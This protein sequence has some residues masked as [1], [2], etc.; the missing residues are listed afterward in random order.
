[1]RALRGLVAYGQSIRMRRTIRLLPPAIGPTSGHVGGS[2]GVPFT[3][4]VI[5]E[6]TAA[7]CGVEDHRYAFAGAMAQSIF[8]STAMPVHWT[9]LGE[10]GATS[11]RIRYRLMPQLV[12]YS[13]LVVLLAGANDV[14]GRRTPREWR[15]NLTAIL[16][17]L[18]ERNTRTIVMGTPP[19]AAFPSL[20]R[21]LRSH[22]AAKGRSFDK[23]SLSVCASRSDAT[24]VS[25]TDGRVD[26]GRDF[27]AADGFHPSVTGYRRWAVL[28]AEHATG[29]R[30]HA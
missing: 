22:L 24:W 12:H 6:S 7:G 3:L 9:A 8:Q 28:A 5:G 4:V 15:D 27:F 17:L 13:D 18:A 29:A 2:S 21:A 16:D 1:M 25:S 30:E 10:L 23:V 26:V 20:P 19:F 11:R 14:L